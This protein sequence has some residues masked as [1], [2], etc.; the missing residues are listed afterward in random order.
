VAEVSK[1]ML[2]LD[3]SRRIDEAREYAQKLLDCSPDDIPN[4]MFYLGAITG[5]TTTIYALNRQ[6]DEAER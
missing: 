6:I 4:Q 1:Q 2:E 5:A 3:R